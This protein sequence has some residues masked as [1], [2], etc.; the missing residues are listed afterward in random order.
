LIRYPSPL[1]TTS[2]VLVTTNSRYHPG[3]YFRRVLYTLGPGI[4]H[5]LAIT[6]ME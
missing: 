1:P 3:Y 4:D 6:R 5:P 2:A